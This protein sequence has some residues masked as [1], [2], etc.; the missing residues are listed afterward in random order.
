VIA[1]GRTSSSTLVFVLIVLLMLWGAYMVPRVTD[2]HRTT[3]R[4]I[5]SELLRQVAEHRVESMEI[6]RGTDVRGVYRRE[7][8]DEEQLKFRCTVPAGQEHAADRFLRLD[9]TLDIEVRE[10]SVGEKIFQY[11]GTLMIPLAII[12]FFYLLMMRQMQSTGSQALSFGRSR[13]RMVSDTF[14]KVTFADVAGMDE[15]KEE[16]QEV[17]DFL[18]DPAK[19]RNLGAKIPRGVLLLGPPGCG[20][21]L[22]AR[23]VAG[24]AGVSFFYISGSDFVEMFVGVGA[25]RVRDLFEQAKHN[26]PAIVFIDEIDAVGRQRG[27]GIGGGH[28][29][30]EQTLNALLVEMDGFDPNADVILLAATN[31]PDILDPALLRP[32]RF[33]RRVVVHNPDVGERKAILDLYVREK[34][35]AED[36]DVDV[37]TRR[38]PGFSGADIENLVNEAALLAARKDK[39]VIE[40]EDF[41]ESVERIVAGPERKSRIIGDKERRILAYHEGGHA[42]VSSMLPGLDR[43]YKVTILPRGMALGYT[44]RLPE[45]D[46]YLMS[47]T[48]MLNTLAYILGGRVAEEV[49]FNEIT[50][51]AQDDLEKATELAREMI[52]EYG[53]SERLGPITFGKKHGPVFLARDLVEERNYSEAIAKEIDDELRRI[54]ES[55]HEKAREIIT[56][57]RDKLERLAE[58]LLEKE[59]VEQEEVAAIVAG[60]EYPEVTGTG[61]AEQPARDAGSSDAEPEPQTPGLPAMPPGLP[62]GQTG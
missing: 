13:A 34:P 51:G 39:T 40:M 12:L 62:D 29:E 21:T 44:I 59:T 35:I 32:G 60:R 3:K 61:G 41:N 26:L 1:V 47:R 17:V 8:E 38:T 10:S 9:P 31:R 18:K 19:F 6:V 27:Y 53:M 28:D 15:V 20:K 4:V 56:S 52:C 45:E 54:V 25:S 11:A 16:L 33:D 37:L 23:A 55:S 43:T 7:G 46:R 36:V 58:V 42:L 24:E 49:V 22:L 30:R 5:Y 50:T 57:N 14:E 48:E 2:A